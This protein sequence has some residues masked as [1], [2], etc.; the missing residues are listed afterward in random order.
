MFRK[1][2]PRAAIVDLDGTLVNSVDAHARAWVAAFREAGFDVS[3]DQVRSL[4]GMP[5]DQLLVHLLGLP[6]SS[7]DAKAILRSRAEIFR[8]RFLGKITPFVGARAL[9]EKLKRQD[10]RVTI[11]ASNSE[12]EASGLL[13]VAG[14]ADLVDEVVTADDARR[15]APDSDLIQVAIRYA[16]SPRD[17]TIVLGDTPFDVESGR[18]AGAS[19]IAFRCGGWGDAALV[20]A[21]AIYDD[22]RDLLNHFSSSPFCPMPSVEYTARPISVLQPARAM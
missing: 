4:L 9:L 21:T 2:R 13:V 1:P 7:E 17:T 11:A 19:V 3:I 20:G 16:G 18:R 14:V 8:T 10:T 6:R 22:P 15:F 12:S 5:P